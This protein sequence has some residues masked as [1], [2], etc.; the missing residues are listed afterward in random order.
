MGIRT[1]KTSH[2]AMSLASLGLTLDDSTGEGGQG[3]GGHFLSVQVAYF[4]FSRPHVVSGPKSPF[5]AY[6]CMH[7]CSDV[8]SDSPTSGIRKFGPI[9]PS[10]LLYTRRCGAVPLVKWGERAD[11]TFLVRSGERWE[12]EA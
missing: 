5:G 8:Q 6:V 3:G 10:T 12:K 4:L 7:A 11:I 9:S 1:R 2:V